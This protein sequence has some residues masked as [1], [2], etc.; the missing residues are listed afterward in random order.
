MKSKQILFAGHIE[1]LKKDVKT[2]A[3]INKKLF[4]AH[5]FEHA[6]N[7]PGSK[8]VSKEEEKANASDLFKEMAILLRSLTMFYNWA[9]VTLTYYALTTM[10]TTFSK[11]IFLNYK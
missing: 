6:K 10:S 4:P 8:M 9:V 7:N 2:T 3:K 5:L 11:N 1:R